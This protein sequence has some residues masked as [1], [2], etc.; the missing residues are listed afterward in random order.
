[1]PECIFLISNTQTQV[2]CLLTK[3]KRK[4]ESR[5]KTANMGIETTIAIIL[6]LQLYMSMINLISIFI[7]E[8]IKTSVFVDCNCLFIIINKVYSLLLYL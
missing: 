7:Y 8:I 6:I 1:M 2:V 4:E 3:K 5:L